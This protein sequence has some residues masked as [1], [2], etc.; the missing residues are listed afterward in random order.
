M[1]YIFIYQKDFAG[2]PIK[3][4]NNGDMYRDFTYIDD[5]IETIDR[6]IFH[7]PLPDENGA[8]Y[9]LYNVGNSHPERLQILL[10]RLKDVWERPQLRNIIRC[11]TAMYTR[12]MRMSAES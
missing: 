1:A 8:K 2:E 10:R 4:F 9:K 12:H 11:R 3:V 5:V 7:P 6:L